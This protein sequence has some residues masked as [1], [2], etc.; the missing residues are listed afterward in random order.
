MSTFGLKGNGILG[1]VSVENP[2][3][4]EYTRMNTNQKSDQAE[5]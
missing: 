2:F 4:R 3:S 1:M 5:F